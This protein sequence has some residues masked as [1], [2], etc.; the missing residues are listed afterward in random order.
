MLQVDDQDEWFELLRQE[1]QDF[2]Q[3]QQATLFTLPLSSRQRKQVHSMA[4]LWGLS[5]MSIGDGRIKRVLV[6]KCALAANVV[7]GNT[8]SRPWNPRSCAWWS[9]TL[10]P[11]LVLIHWISSNVCV[12]TCLSV[13]GLPVPVNVTM[14]VRGD[15]GTAYVLFSSSAD[16]ANVILRDLGYTSASSIVDSDYSHATSLSKKRKREPMIPNGYKCTIDGCDKAF[17]HDGERRK[18]ERNHGGERPY[19]C[20]RCGK[21][22]LYPKDLRRHARTHPGSAQASPTLERVSDASDVEELNIGASASTVAPSNTHPFGSILP[23]HVMPAMDTNH[24]TQPRHGISRF[25]SKIADMFGNGRRHA[26]RPDMP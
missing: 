9:G 6:S 17:D 14:D 2:R 20:R 1:L 8:L 15:Y 5:H 10:D 23:M 3:S 26:R 21:G 4:N 16:A 19:V 24:T 12:Q 13:L 11:R 7:D 25:S 18:H 22:F